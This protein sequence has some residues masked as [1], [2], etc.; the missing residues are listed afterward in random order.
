MKTALITLIALS[1]FDSFNSNP[2]LMAEPSETRTIFEQMPH[3]V[4]LLIDVAHLKVSAKTLKFDPVK[5]LS[6]FEGVT[7]AYH[8]SDNNGLED[9][10]KPFTKDS[11]FVRHI[12]KDLKYYSLEVYVSDISV[13]EKQYALLSEILR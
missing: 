12:R 10:N 11:W 6:D 13:L 1:S 8:I 4:K 5:F 7:A 3:N 2:L 9:S